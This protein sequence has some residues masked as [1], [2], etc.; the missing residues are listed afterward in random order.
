MD[1]SRAVAARAGLWFARTSDLRAWATLYAGN[2]GGTRTDFYAAVAQVLPIL[3]L[4]VVVEGRML[5]TVPA[6]P[7]RAYYLGLIVW[8][9]AGEA[10][11]LV[12]LGRGSGSSFLFH[13]AV[14]GLGYGT[15]AL[16]IMGLTR[17][18]G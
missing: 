2:G 3:V 15:F 13:A 11:S 12:A 18:I 10:A 5:D 8:A 1:L 17:S 7:M 9:V 16:A 14:A 4:A 6:A